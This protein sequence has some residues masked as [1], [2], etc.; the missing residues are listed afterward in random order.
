M[1]W[2]LLFGFFL[3]FSLGIFTPGSIAA[4]EDWEVNLNVRDNGTGSPTPDNIVIGMAEQPDNFIDPPYPPSPFFAWSIE[5]DFESFM[6]LRVEH[7]EE[8]TW[9]TQITADSSQDDR[10][11]VQPVIT[12]SWKNKPQDKEVLMLVGEDTVDLKR[13]NRYVWENMQWSYDRAYL[14]PEFVVGQ[15]VE[16]Y[17]L[18]VK[19]LD[20]TPKLAEPGESVSV[21]AEVK[22]L[23]DETLDKEATLYVD[24]D[25][26]ISESIELSGNQSKTLSFDVS[27]SQ[28][29]SYDVRLEVGDEEVV[30]E[31]RIRKILEDGS[32]EITDLEVNPKIV[33]RGENVEITGK[34]KNVGDV[35]EEQV[36]ALYVENEVENYKMIELSGGESKVFDFIISREKNGYYNI[37]VEM[38]DHSQ[39]DNFLVEESSQVE[40]VEIENLSVK[41]K[42]VESGKSVTVSGLVKNDGETEQSF[43]IYFYVENEEESYIPL[44][45]LD[46][47]DN[48]R[49][50]FESSRVEEGNYQ[51]SVNVMGEEATT[52]FSVSVNQDFS[53]GL[54]VYVSAAIIVATIFLAI[55]WKKVI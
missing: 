46:P 20:I 53:E 7:S 11:Q 55:V 19:A 32:F 36:L 5:E 3:V 10:D 6:Q 33:R 23:T 9:K 18:K 41:P 43:G 31:F 52:S 15:D 1:K 44:V 22:N 16:G 29:K 24:D 14:E 27:K 28:E 47:G 2:V 45:E 48:Y 37:R 12:W 54:L 51:V 4:S 8:Y 49:F 50:E 13:E 38:G 39:T 25:I 42:V 30:G 34:V 21:S 35:L 40:M 17:P 26:E